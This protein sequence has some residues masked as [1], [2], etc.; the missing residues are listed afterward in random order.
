VAF[1]DEATKQLSL[2]M[3]CQQIPAADSVVEAKTTICCPQ[4]QKMGEAKNQLDQA[5]LI[6]ITNQNF[7]VHNSAQFSFSQN[8]SPS[9]TFCKLR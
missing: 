4:S 5:N 8:N 1:E 3:G 7:Q 2:K 9:P 6:P